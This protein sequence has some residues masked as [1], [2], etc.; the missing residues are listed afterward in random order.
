VT[1]G[2]VNASNF[3][4]DRTSDHWWGDLAELAIYDRPLPDS[5]RIAVENYFRMK[6]WTV[7]AQA[8]AGSVSLTWTA[9]PNTA[10]YEVERST[11]SGSGYATIATGLL[12]TAYADTTVASLTTYYYRVIAVDTSGSR[13]PSREVSGTALFIGTGTG[14]TG[15]YHNS[16]DLSDPPVLVRVDP[17]VDFNF[18]NGSPDPVVNVDGFS[19]RWTGQVQAPV[20]GD[21]VFS[22][23]SSDGVRLRIDGQ[24]VID[25]WTDHGDTQNTSVPIRLEVGQMYDV[26]LE[27]YERAS[28]ALIRLK[29]SYPGQALQTIP[30]TQLYP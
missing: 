9:F 2:P 27:Y 30:Q 16:V 29:W 4:Q 3:G 1:T 25:N 17:V 15:T 24:L 20:S 13:V 5:E 26:S 6:Y 22:T 12:G 21:F 8:G 28:S 23:N 14:L 10:R 7:T 19:A 11:T 18:G